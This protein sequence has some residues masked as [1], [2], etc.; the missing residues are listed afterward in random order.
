MN[1]DI[2]TLLSQLKKAINSMRWFDSYV[3]E[4]KDRLNLES[5]YQVA[6]YLEVSRQYLTKVRNGQPLGRQ[7]CIRIARA[8]RRDPLEII[9]TA[10]AQREKDPDLKA[11]WVKLAKEKGNTD[12]WQSVH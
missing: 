8:L 6:K 2:K 10:E 4:L 5:D 9:A 11:I 1:Y 7:H 3:D 12:K